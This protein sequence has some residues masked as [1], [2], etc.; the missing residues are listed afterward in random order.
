[1]IL[2]RWVWSRIFFSNSCLCVTKSHKPF[3]TFFMEPFASCN[4]VSPIPLCHLWSP[5]CWSQLSYPSPC[6]LTSHIIW[7]SCSLQSCILWSQSPGRHRSLVFHFTPDCLSLVL[8]LLPHLP[9]WGCLR[10]L[11]FLFEIP[12]S[13]TSHYLPVFPITWL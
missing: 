3:F 7:Q 2:A 10:T 13:I 12:F 4:L 9:A 6:F 1:M 8:P 5:P 11:R